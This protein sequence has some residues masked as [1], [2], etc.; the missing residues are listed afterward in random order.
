MKTYQSTQQ[1][2]VLP[3]LDDEDRGPVRDEE[4]AWDARVADESM[5]AYPYRRF[6]E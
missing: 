6:V 2:D 5:P 1:K 4:P 3:P